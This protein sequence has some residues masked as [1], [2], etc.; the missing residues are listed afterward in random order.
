MAVNLKR[1]ARWCAA[2]LIGL[3]LGC[4]FSNV[5]ASP[6]SEI[7]PVPVYRIP[8]GLELE[9][10]Q[11]SI[12]QLEYHLQ[13]VQMIRRMIETGDWAGLGRMIGDPTLTGLIDQLEL[14]LK[15]TK[16][17]IYDFKNLNPAY[18]PVEASSAADYARKLAEQS[19][20][21]AKGRSQIL[22]LMTERYSD[23]V[24]DENGDL[25][26]YRR[27]NSMP[28]YIEYATEANISIGEELA[29]LNQDPEA[30]L[31]RAMQLNTQV[32]LMNHAV[33]VKMLQN[34]S[35]QNRL[36]TLLIGAVAG[37]D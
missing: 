7:L 10:A 13:Q 17:A 16:K 29:K 21:A 11:R 23:S 19:R 22:T 30:G 33:L 14:T 9:E 15:S 1:T 26:E 18:E 37:A 6:V 34:L 12:Q 20:I 28:A 24:V 3:A 36:L 25:V 8:I 35:D 2:F 31:M 27:G 5:A 32:A 4:S